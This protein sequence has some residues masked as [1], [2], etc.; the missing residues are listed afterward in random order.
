MESDC[1]EAVTRPG[2]TSLN[3]AHSRPQPHRRGLAVSLHLWSSGESRPTKSRSPRSSARISTKYFGP[4]LRFGSIVASAPEPAHR[5][6]SSSHLVWSDQDRRRPAV[7][8]PI[9][10]RPYSAT[11]PW[12]RPAS[13]SSGSAVGVSIQAR[14]KSSA[15]VN[16]Q[17]RR[18]PECPTASPSP[19]RLNSSF[20]SEGLGARRQGRLDVQNRQ[21]CRRR[22]PPLY[23]RRSGFT[24]RLA[25]GQARVCCHRR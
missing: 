22:C 7:R 18:P 2:L 3:R 6:D 8:L 20:A 16:C 19:K 25:T 4:P 15:S 24:A 12:R 23:V 5:P 13:M 14:T 21:T 11:K 10:R 9:G 1:G 17:I